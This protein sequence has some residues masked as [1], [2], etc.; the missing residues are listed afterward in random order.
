MPSNVHALDKCWFQIMKLSLNN[1]ILL[2]KH[3]QYNTFI[4]FVSPFVVWLSINTTTYVEYV[5]NSFFF[6]SETLGTGENNSL[7]SDQMKNKKLLKDINFK[8]YICNH[9][10]FVKNGQNFGA[11]NG[12]QTIFCT[13]VRIFLICFTYRSYFYHNDIYD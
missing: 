10:W 13:W 6:I 1:V 9:F 11:Q 12:P 4:S 8:L 5:I 3:Y 2:N 7:S